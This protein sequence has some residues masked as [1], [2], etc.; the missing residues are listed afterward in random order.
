MAEKI[1]QTRI[2]NKHADLATWTSSTLPLKTG[3]IALARVE[4]TRPD[5]NGG[6]YTVPTYLM[7]VGDGEKTFSQLEWLAAPAS[8]VYEWAKAT[9]KPGY[10]ATEITRGSS[11]VAADLVKVEDD[12]TNLK[13]AI[14]AGGSVADAI[15]AAIEALDVDDAVVANQ[16]VTAVAEAD[17]KI[18][19]TR[20]A[21]E[22]EDIP[23]LGIDKITGLQDALNLKANA[24]DVKDTTDAISARL[25]TGDIKEAI[26][27]AK[28]AGDDAKTYAE[29]IYKVEGETRTGVLAQYMTSNDAEVAAVRAIAEAARDESEVDSQIDAKL[30]TFKSTVTDKIEE[31]VAKNA[32]D[33]S[34]E[35]TRA[36]AAEGALAERVTANE[37]AIRTLNAATTFA[38]TGTYAEMLA[39]EVV[40]GSIFVVID[41]TDE[42]KQYNNKE[43]VYD[44]SK[45]VEL[46]DTTAELNEINALKERVSTIETDLGENGD[47]TKAIAAAQEAADAA[48]EDADEANRLIGIIN[49]TGEGSISKAVEDATSALQTYADGKA[50]AAQN[51]AKDYTDTEVQKANDA[52][53][54]AQTAIDTH[55]GKKDNPHEVTKEQVGLGNVDNKS[56]AEIKTEFT[57]AVADGND[58]FV[59]GDAAYDAIEAAKTAVNGYTDTEVQKVDDKA[60]ANATEITT[61]KNNY[62]RISGDNLV[63]GQGENEMVIIFDCGGAN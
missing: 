7:K 45:W 21:L 17:G 43:F 56:V 33:I 27:A 15:K 19:V 49:G 32:T 40:A 44:G 23:A 26:D 25:D 42:G 36:T 24:S 13:T 37:E 30:A 59:T 18:S 9:T 51:A 4:A 38:G 53:A 52:A 62:A 63:Y 2:I 54:A 48:Q 34:S 58:K 57:G 46:G 28:T 14:G 60:T 8:D 6:F 16:F 41:T 55:A 29:G 35:T 61:I 31:R 1:L 10:T 39:K 47:T 20:R 12:I 3:E 5:G 22:A 11:N 50:S